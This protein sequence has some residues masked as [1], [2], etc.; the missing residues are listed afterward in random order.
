MI[1]LNYQ[2]HFTHSRS[3]LE[4]MDPDDRMMSEGSACSV[5]CFDRCDDA[6][7]FAYTRFGHDRA[8]RIHDSATD[9]LIDVIYLDLIVHPVPD[10]GV[11]F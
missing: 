1:S 3:E 11:P 4:A 2:V 9:H 7:S 10:S 8:V 6:I 5:R